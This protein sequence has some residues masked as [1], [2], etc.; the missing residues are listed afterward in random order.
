[1]PSVYAFFNVLIFFSIMSKI[2]KLIFNSFSSTER[3]RQLGCLAS[4]AATLVK[5]AIKI[6]LN[7]HAREIKSAAAD[8]GHFGAISYALKNSF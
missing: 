7:I 3:A 2:A 1:M 5:I 6:P 8:L 4:V